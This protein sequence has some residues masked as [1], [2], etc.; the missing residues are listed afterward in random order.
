VKVSF[1]GLGRMGQIMA[2][3]L[4]DAKVD[5]MVQNRSA[6]KCRALAE[7][8]A[9]VADTVV[10]ACAY[11]G[12]VITMLADDAALRAVAQGPGGILAS[13]PAGGIHIV[14]GTHRIET[15]RELAAAQSA[16]GQFLVAAPVLGRPAVAAAGKLGI[17]AAGPADVLKTVQPLFDAIGRRT[18]GA[19]S[20]PENASLLKLCNNMVLACAIEAMGEAFSLVEKAGVEKQGLQDVLTKGLF[21]CIAY[22][23]YAKTIVERNWDSVNISA[24][25]ALKDIKLVLDVA[26]T[27]H[28]SLPSALLC[29]DR[30]LAAEAHG[31]AQRDWTVMALEQGRASGLNWDTK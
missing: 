8:G 4:L 19:G 20:A 14:M 9:K 17:I 24:Q 13:L 26:D 30:L 18:F 2:G 3:R 27:H 29:R 11:G 25:L 6:D 5:L 15:I 16:A 7:R 31:N 22:E 23:G 12:P 28:V 21:E 1:I 10:Q